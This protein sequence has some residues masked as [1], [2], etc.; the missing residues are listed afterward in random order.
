MSIGGV[1]VAAVAAVVGAQVAVIA[2]FVIGDV[3]A[4]VLAV[5]A[6]VGVDGS[7]RAVT[8]QVDPATWKALCT[9]NGGEVIGDF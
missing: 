2:G 8:K 6:I 3:E 9:R 1:A 4:I 5:A 7:V